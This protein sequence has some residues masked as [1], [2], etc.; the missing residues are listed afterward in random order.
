MVL[1][2]FLINKTVTGSHTSIGN[3]SSDTLQDIDLWVYAPNGSLVGSSLTLYNNVENI[4]FT[5]AQTGTYTI[6][7]KKTTNT[8]T[9]PVTFGV[10]WMEAN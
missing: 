3:V 4:E 8:Y 7:V 1:A 5:S 2:G 9:T 10:A 6:K